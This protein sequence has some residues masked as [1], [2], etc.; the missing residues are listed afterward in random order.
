[1]F[2]VVIICTIDT[3]YFVTLCAIALDIDSIFVFLFAIT[4]DFIR[5][6][7]VEKALTNKNNIKPEHLDGVAAEFGDIA[8]FAYQLIAQICLDSER[9][10]LATEANRRALKLNPFLWQPFKSLCDFGQD[11]NPNDV[12]KF[13]NADIF[14]TCQESFNSNS[15]FI[16]AGCEAQDISLTDSDGDS[17]RSYSIYATP[18]MDQH[19]AEDRF[20]TNVSFFFSIL[21]LLYS[22]YLVSSLSIFIQFFCL[23]LDAKYFVNDICVECYRRRS[24]DDRKFCCC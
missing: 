12:Y 19:S 11:V 9:N 18:V 8:C 5:F 24:I 16:F 7:C 20:N 3:I 15:S 10:D 4:L 2:V 21:F 6:S 22:T 17:N 14:Q 23:Q 13:E 1:M